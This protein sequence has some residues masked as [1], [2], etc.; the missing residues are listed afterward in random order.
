MKVTSWKEVFRLTLPVGMG[1]LPTGFAFGVLA[2]QSGLSPVITVAMSVFIFAGAL[3]FAAVPLLAAAGGTGTIALTTL[4]VNLRHVLYAIPLLN[5]LPTRRASRAYVVAVLT[6]E[7]Y[8]LL[9]T[10]PESRRRDVA[11]RVSLIN[12]GYW[13]FGTI[14]GVVL[15]AQA[16]RWIPNLGFALPALFTILAIEQYLARKKWL[17]AAVGLGCYIVARIALPQYALISALAFGLIVLISMA[18]VRRLPAPRRD[19]DLGA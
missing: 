12:H 4:L 13:V 3:Q 9:T 7:N 10:I 19:L 16:T 1:Y 8:S 6:D 11:V 18:P 2:I 14:L 5:D 15:G 17:P